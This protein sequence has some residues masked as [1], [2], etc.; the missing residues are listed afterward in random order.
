MRGAIKSPIF[1]PIPADPPPEER[2]LVAVI[3]DSISLKEEIISAVED[4]LLD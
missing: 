4:E 3:R 1:I 2:L